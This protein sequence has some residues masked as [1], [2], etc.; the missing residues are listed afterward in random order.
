MVVVVSGHGEPPAVDFGYTI[1]MPETPRTPPAF[2]ALADG[3]DRINGAI[4][5]AAAWAALF[6]VAM[7]FLVVLLR[8]WFGIGSIWATES[9]IYGNAAM[10]MLA[11]AWTLRDGGHVRV[12]VFYAEASPRRRA[13]IDLAGALLLLLP[14]MMVMAWFALPYVARSW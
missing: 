10:V 7:Q 5:Q 13:M 14:F 1:A 3:I 2:L 8:Y 4:G 9:I 6:V 12:D 11:A